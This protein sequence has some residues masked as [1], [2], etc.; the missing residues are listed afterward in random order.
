MSDVQQDHSSHPGPTEYVQIGIILAVITGIE[1]ALYYADAGAFTVPAL[2][3]L[4]VVKFGLVIFWFMHLRFDSPVF[5]RLFFGGLVLAF[6]L[7]AIVATTFY[8]GPA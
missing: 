3:F 4:T 7:F 5:R 6:V 1:V 2:L 8:F